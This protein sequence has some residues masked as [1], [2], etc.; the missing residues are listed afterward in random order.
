MGHTY[1]C[2]IW[3]LLYDKLWGPS[4]RVVTLFPL[5]RLKY[6]FALNK[7]FGQTSLTGLKALSK[8]LERYCDCE[9]QKGFFL[10][11]VGLYLQVSPIKIVHEHVFATNR[12]QIRVPQIRPARLKCIATHCC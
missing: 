8:Q 7:V 2:Q 3:G 5:E 4:Q 11:F 1:T 12:T 10:S 6:L 9:V